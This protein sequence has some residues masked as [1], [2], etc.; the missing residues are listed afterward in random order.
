MSNQYLTMTDAFRG[1]VYVAHT[2]HEAIQELEHGEDC[3]SNY[4][5]ADD[6][7]WLATTKEHIEYAVH[8][9]ESHDELVREVTAL[10]NKIA[11]MESRT[12]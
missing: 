11:E 3:G 12:A 4:H 6:G 8:A 2:D 7:Y 9:I 10:R 5:L 1:K